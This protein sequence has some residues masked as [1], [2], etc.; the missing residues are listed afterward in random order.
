MLSLDFLTPAEASA[1]HARR[2]RELRLYH[3]WTHEEL[4][5][6]A[7]ITVASLKRFENT[8]QIS[9]DRLLSIAMAL[10]ALQDFEQLFPKPAAKTLSD[11]EKQEVTRQRGRR[12][13]TP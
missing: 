5:Q 2:V 13:K 8:G 6:R 3:E 1:L 4:A 9:L 7:G 11:L 10:G 12:R